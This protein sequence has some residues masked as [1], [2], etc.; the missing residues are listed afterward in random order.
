MRVP[1]VPLSDV[2]AK[3]KSYVI[4]MHLRAAGAAALTSLK[5]LVEEQ[6][7]EVSKCSMR[8]GELVGSLN[9]FSVQYRT[10]CNLQRCHCDPHCNLA[11]SSQHASARSSNTV[12]GPQHRMCL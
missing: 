12:S 3:H 10:I 8:I 5:G 11:A 9:Y 1:E 7:Q 6:N 2:C 4:E